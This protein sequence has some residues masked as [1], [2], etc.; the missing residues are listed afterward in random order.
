MKY[1][2]MFL[3]LSFIFNAYADIEYMPN[4]VSSAPSEQEISKNRACFQELITLG[5]GDPA[6]DSE[7]F[8]SCMANVYPNLSKSCQ[9]L[10]S[11]LYGK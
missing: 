1:A 7:H 3:T 6:E 4:E 2:L 10:M 11:I 5:C 8:R 9:S